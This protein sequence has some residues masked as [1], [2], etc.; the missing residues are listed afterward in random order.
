MCPPPPASPAEPDQEEELSVQEAYTPESTCWGCGEPRTH[1]RTPAQ[2]RAWGPAGLP[3]CLPAWAAVQHRTCRALR[4]W[5]G[6][7]S[8]VVRGRGGDTEQRRLPPWARN[9]N[10]NAATWPHAGPAAGDGLNLR[11][12]RIPGGLEAT[13]ELSAKYSAFPGAWVAG[14]VAL[15]QGRRGRV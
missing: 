6:G 8:A 15:Q 3:A 10:S 13:V 4:G 14:W 12:Y 7:C 9:S 1:A 2:R 11:S 5:G